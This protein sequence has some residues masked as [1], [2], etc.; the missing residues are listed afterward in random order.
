MAPERSREFIRKAEHPIGIPPA[1]LGWVHLP[2]QLLFS[3]PLHDAEDLLLFGVGQA[4]QQR[5]DEFF[6][7]THDDG[8]RLSGRDCRAHATQLAGSV[9][10]GCRL[11]LQ[12]MLTA[13]GGPVQGGDYVTSDDF[14]RPVGA[15]KSLPGRSATPAGATLLRPSL[16]R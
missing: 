4:A 15:S 14:D 10:S 16:W 1:A 2:V 12:A 13:A 7:E 6:V 11:N 5:R 8:P 3:S 9:G